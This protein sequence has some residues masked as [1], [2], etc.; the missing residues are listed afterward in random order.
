MIVGNFFFIFHCVTGSIV[1]TLHYTC[2]YK[3]IMLNQLDFSLFSTKCFPLG[4][5]CSV[6]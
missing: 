5:F 1:T 6:I 2:A 4:H 3:S